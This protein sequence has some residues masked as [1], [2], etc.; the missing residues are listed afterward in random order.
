MLCA[1]TKSMNPDLLASVLAQNSNASALEELISNLQP[2]KESGHGFPLPYESSSQEN[3]DLTQLLSVMA[4]AVAQPPDKTKSFA[5]IEDE[6]KFLYGDEEEDKFSAKEM[7][8]CVQGNLLNVYEKTRPDGVHHEPKTGVVHDLHRNEYGHSYSHGQPEEDGGQITKPSKYQDKH[9]SSVSPGQHLDEEPQSNPPVTGS[10]D[11]QVRA[12]VEEYE[13]IQDL[14][15]TI[16]LDLGVA[17]ISKMAARTQERLQGKNP[18]K[19]S[20]KRHQSDRRHRSHSRSSS[21]SSSR[22]RSTSR[23]SSCS[24]RSSRSSSYD[25]TPSRG[26]KKSIPIERHSSRSDR[27]GQMECQ[28]GVKTEDN[29]WTNTGP[30]PPEVVNPGTTNF[31]AHS[32]HQM[33]PYQ[34]PHP[35][36]VMPPNYPPPGY[37]LYGNYMP[38]MPQGW[39]MYPPPSMPMP[40]QTPMDDYS[41]PAIERP[42]LKVINTGANEAQGIETKGEQLCGHFIFSS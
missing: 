13:K 7:P 2:T 25:H 29:P 33:P 41:S 14:L 1:V 21:S 34:Q 23:G 30:P 3:S 32:A 22:S 40:P 9:Y 24:R 12:E 37:D 42:F 20:V 15:K 36:G 31:P 18:G 6:E 11:A 19:S 27:E 16:G 8:K 5:D 4:E 35:R 39:P 26:R 38:Y 28:P 17:E 10:H